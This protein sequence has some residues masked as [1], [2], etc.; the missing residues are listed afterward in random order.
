MK[1]PPRFALLNINN[2]RVISLE[3]A[4]QRLY[5]YA[6]HHSENRFV[7]QSQSFTT[8]SPSFT[9]LGKGQMIKYLALFQPQS[10]FVFASAQA[11]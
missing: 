7:H 9:T 8:N 11:T 5:P 10:V 6:I 3:K 1:L 4:L 2:E